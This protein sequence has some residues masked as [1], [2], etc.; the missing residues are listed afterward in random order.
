MI[1]GKGE[2]EKFGKVDWPTG[3]INCLGK[4]DIQETAGLLKKCDIFI[5]NDSGPAH[6]AAALRVPMYVLFGPTRISKNQP[7]GSRVNVITKNIHCSPCQ[8]TKRWDECKDW[9]CMSQ[10]TVED[11]LQAIG[12]ESSQQQER[13]VSVRIPVE[14]YQ[15]TKKILIV[16]VLDVASSTN[17]FMKKGFEKLGWL[18]DGYNYRTRMQELGNPQ[19]MW[20]DFRRF[21]N[22]KR[23]GLIVFCKV[24]SLHPELIT[25]AGQYGKTWYW[26]MDHLGAAQEIHADEY[27]KR[28]D[29]ASATSEEVCN[30]FRK[31][32][33]NTVQIVEGFDQE[34]YFYEGIPK[35]YDVLFVGNATEKRIN[36]LRLIRNGQTLTI[37]GSG[38]QQE[39]GARP[40]I[41]NEEL[42]KA[43]CESKIVLNLVHSNI[44]SDRVVL[45]AASGGFVLSQACPDLERH[46]QR[47]VHLDWFR[48]AEEAQQLIH[49][50][51]EHHK[52]REKIAKSGM[53]YVRQKYNWESVCREILQKTEISLPQGITTP[54]KK[55]VER[56]L[57]VSWH[58]LGDNVMLTPALRKYKQQHP[59][60]YVAVA[61]LERFGNTLVQ[62]LSGL[63][64]I[65]EVIPCLP[66]AWND[67]PDYK[68]GVDAVVERAQAI[69]RERGFSKVVVLPT[70]RQ[71][72][73]KLHKIFRFADEVGVQFNCLEDLQT[74]LTVTT[75][76]EKRVEEH[77]KDYSK[78]ILVL[79][80]KAG[81]H[82]KT[83][84]VEDVEQII[85]RYQ[86]YTIF[87]FGRRS[88]SR[89]I[90]VSENDMEFSKALIKRADM[91]IAIDSVVMHIAGAFQRPLLAIFT[92]TPIHQVIPLPY[93][94]DT[95]GFDNQQ[96]QLSNWPKLRKEMQD[97]FPRCVNVSFDERWYFEG[98]SGCY[99]GYW[100]GGE[101]GHGRKY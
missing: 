67:F 25:Y 84:A 61:G 5:G 93:R 97:K 27:V 29:F 101:R 90:Q 11:V 88:T 92:M 58:G 83:L 74:E 82:P 9:Q 85:N 80:A 8:Y 16:G 28:A 23:Y 99:Q 66:D 70:N 89:S 91:V 15:D 42:R 10:I 75:E 34:T 4:C 79:H 77:I 26:F 71:E 96:T 47:K 65:D 21:L 18:V 52:E 73:Y 38:W 12:K 14:N 22:G 86:G 1:G 50:Y 59:D 53:H 41:Y 35:V 32:N 48:N 95:I 40:P 7:R 55:T 2:A 78:P 6:L 76:A 94:V 81:N 68:T 51:L 87:E 72:G 17:V 69:G 57:F 3:V 24:N 62:L 63:H 20:D 39:F 13:E 49:Y 33:P 44:F 98:G 60:S 19:A 54:H 37:F 64:F 43:I 36:E 30:W 56:I 45:T 46:F 31:L 100:W